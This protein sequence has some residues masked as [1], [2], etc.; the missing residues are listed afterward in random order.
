[1][2]VGVC[3]HEKLDKVL[4]EPVSPLGVDPTLDRPVML[5][6]RRRTGQDHDQA[7]YLLE[8]DSTTKLELIQVIKDL[9]YSGNC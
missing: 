4:T 8:H 1:M 6:C 9:L 7:F 3:T 2:K 5:T